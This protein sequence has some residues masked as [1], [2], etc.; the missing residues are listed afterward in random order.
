MTNFKRDYNFAEVVLLV[1]SGCRSDFRHFSLT[2]V[3]KGNWKGCVILVNPSRRFPK[4]LEHFVR[5]KTLQ[6]VTRTT[7]SLTTVVLHRVYETEGEE[8]QVVV[9]R[10]FHRLEDRP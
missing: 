7:G 9:L 3:S 6:R 8:C 4:C 1:D 10:T 2:Y 5:A